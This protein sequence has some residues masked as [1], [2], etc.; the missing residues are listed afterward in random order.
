M[1]E[2]K[3]NNIGITSF[4][5]ARFESELILSHMLREDIIFRKNPDLLEFKKKCYVDPDLLAAERAP[6]KVPINKKT[7]DK[8][9]F[10]YGCT[11]FIYSFIRLTLPHF[12]VQTI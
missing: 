3:H 8:N 2:A 12:S 5:R 9:G 10:T 4:N 6:K 1:K 7:T 11:Y